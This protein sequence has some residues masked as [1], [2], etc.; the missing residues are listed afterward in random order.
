[1]SRPDVRYPVLFL[2]FDHTI[3]DSDESERLAFADAMVAA[4]VPDPALHFPTYQQINR[5]LWAAV[6][7]G[8]L[9]TD[10]VG[11]RRFEEL[12]EAIGT[13]ADPVLVAEVYT[14]GMAAHGTLY[15]GAIETLHQLSDV[16]RMA[17]VTN[18]ISVIQRTRIERV[19]IAS[20]FE[21]IVISS[22]VG[23]AK[24]DP[25]IFDLAFEWMGHPSTRSVLMVGD[26]LSS[27]IT[28]GSSYGID[29]CW[30]NPNGLEPSGP[31]PSHVIGSIAD[32]PAVVFG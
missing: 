1:M 26:S 2:D 18:A 15:P 4:R 11:V 29:T 12:I 5:R 16:V 27:D 19:G 9:D 3:F 24:P 7:R 30:V 14:A 6:E 13:D 20:F 17:L 32:L 8:E 31:V 25:G 21:T 10:A 23:V 28:G 22:E